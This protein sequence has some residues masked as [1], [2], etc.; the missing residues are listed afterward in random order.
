MPTIQAR[1]GIS[2]VSSSYGPAPTVDPFDLS[3]VDLLQP[4]HQQNLPYS[5]SQATPQQPN[6]LQ[7]HQMLSLMMAMQS[8]PAVAQEMNKLQELVNLGYLQWEEFVKRAQELNKSAGSS[9]APAQKPSAANTININVSSDTPA[10]FSASPLRDIAYSLPANAN[11]GDLQVEAFVSSSYSYDLSTSHWRPV[12]CMLR[13]HLSTS[14]VGSRCG[15]AT[16]ACTWKGARRRRH[17]RV[18][19]CS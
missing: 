7:A 9:D 16:A 13:G 5:G 10:A 18:P 17:L 3:S 2:A 6:V 14:G 15:E 8:N 12:T 11:N 4:L 1:R 19:S